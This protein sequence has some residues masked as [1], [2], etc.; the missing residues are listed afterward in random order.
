MTDIEI[1]GVD[2]T[3]EA[4]SKQLEL[5]KRQATA[6]V[7]LAGNEYKNDVQKLAPHKTGTYRRS[8]H[9]EPTSGVMYD[10]GQPY[11]LVGTNLDYAKRLEYGFWNMVDRIGRRFFQRAQPHFRPALD[12]NREKY[13]RIMQG[14]FDRNSDEMLVE[15]EY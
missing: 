2:Q 3:I 7:R 1:T 8:I 6:A 4:I 11:V 9:V 15:G 14:V 5:K 10:G 12:L 13:I